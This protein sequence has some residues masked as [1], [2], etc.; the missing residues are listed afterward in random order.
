MKYKESR[1]NCVI[2]KDG[3][4]LIYN[5]LANKFYKALCTYREIKKESLVEHK[6]KISNE[7]DEEKLAFTKFIRLQEDNSRLQ[8]I[9]LPTMDC[10]FRC[11]Y[12]YE[13]K[14]SEFMSEEVQSAIINYVRQNIRG[15]KEISISWFGGEPLLCKNIVTHICSEV[16][17]MANYYHIQFHSG[18][19]TNG[20]LLDCETFR[21]L[22]QHNIREYQITLDGN[23]ETHNITRPLRSGAGSY[24]R[25]LEN[26]KSI[27]D[28]VKTRNFNIVVRVN[29]TKD[30]LDE[31]QEIVQQIYE[32][33]GADRRFQ[34]YFKEVGDYGGDNVT[35]MKEQLISDPTGIEQKLLQCPYQF[36]L[37]SQYNMFSWNPMCYAACHYSH[38]IK[39]N[40]DIAKCTVYFSHP[41]N[42]I[43]KLMP[44]G[45]MIFNEKQYHWDLVGLEA[46][47]SKKCGDCPFYANCFHAGC[48]SQQA[49]KGEAIQSD[50]NCSLKERM[51]QAI[52]VMYRHNPEVFIE[53]ERI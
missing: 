44:N 43:G 36:N 13:E 17:K 12:C 49:V 41:N 28:N 34:F 9:I 38:V 47:K 51:Y 10:N 53:L 8:L 39:P 7:I 20:Y 40:G 50:T 29:M 2:E 45:S 5:S 30:S 3:Y 1:Y 11:T 15:K 26:L 16:K 33:F 31:F 52:E 32:E 19:T 46:Y 14:I 27:R 24:L 6:L 48:P 23:Q 21:Q 42:Q 35:K 18:M 22:L 25:I 4:T 37:Q